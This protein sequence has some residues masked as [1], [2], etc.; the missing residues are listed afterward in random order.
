MAETFVRAR[1]SFFGA[2]L[3]PGY[4]MAQVDIVKDKVYKTD[5]LGV[6][7]RYPAAEGQPELFEALEPEPDPTPV[8][9]ARP[10]RSKSE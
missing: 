4:E 8:R 1:E 7:G 9:T 10:P 3:K 2:S 5:H 6:F